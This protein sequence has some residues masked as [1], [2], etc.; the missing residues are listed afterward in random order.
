MLI[1]L[2]HAHVGESECDTEKEDKKLNVKGNYYLTNRSDA[3]GIPRRTLPNITL[4]QSTRTPL[5][6]KKRGCADGATSKDL[7]I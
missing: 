7:F 3:L 2:S 1:K 5:G 4:K 6:Q